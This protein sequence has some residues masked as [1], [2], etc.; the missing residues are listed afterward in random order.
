MYIATLR[1]HIEAMGGVSEI[2]A[3]FPEGSVKIKSFESS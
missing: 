3:A 2:V 1:A